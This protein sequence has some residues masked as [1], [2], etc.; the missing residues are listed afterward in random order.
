M[1]KKKGLV[2]LALVTV[3]SLGS[4]LAVILADFTPNLGLDLQGGVSVVLQPVKA[5]KKQTK[6][7]Q[8]ALEQTQAGHRDP[9][10]RDRRR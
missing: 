8:E 3:L 4:C 1:K 7:S 2:P 5:G 9:C 10:E 6:V